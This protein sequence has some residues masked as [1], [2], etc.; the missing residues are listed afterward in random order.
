MSVISSPR[1]IHA[2]LLTAIARDHDADAL[3][4]LYDAYGP[5][6][7]AC[8]LRVL[9]D[10][11]AAEE[12]VQEAFFKVWRNAGS[13]V[14]EKGSVRN[15]VLSIVQ[16]Q[17]LDKLRRIRS[18]QRL[19][20]Q[21]QCAEHN[22]QGPDVWPEVL[23]LLERSRMVHA[24]RALPPKQRQALELAYYGGYTHSEIAQCLRIPLGT[25]KGRLRLGI[26]KLRSILVDQPAAP[27][28]CM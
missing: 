13:Y 20:V 18:R 10:T 26:D 14:E 9:G 3:A 16:H 5:L 23:A 4:S 2:E 7:Y 11:E 22:M 12:V 28:S 24:L 25:V 17:S 21:F 1:P 19:D 27:A 15:W 6:A 8:S